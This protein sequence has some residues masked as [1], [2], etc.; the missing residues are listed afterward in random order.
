MT[1]KTSKC[2]P[3]AAKSIFSNPVLA[4]KTT[5]IPLDVTHQVIA[6]IRVQQRLLHGSPHLLKSPASNLR[7]MLYDLLLF[8]AHTYTEVFGFTVGPPLHDPIAVAVIL[9]HRT[10]EELQFDDRGGERW[11]VDVITDGM[12]ST[13]G[14]HRGQLGRIVAKVAATEDGMCI[15]RG[16]DVQRF[17]AILEECVQQAERT[18]LT[19]GAAQSQR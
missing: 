7:Q 13:L 4:R 3:E 18:L 9:S 12:H 19:P 11:N 8:F 14:E 16:L 17:W 6:D 15:P 10:N 2:D 5:L 1:A